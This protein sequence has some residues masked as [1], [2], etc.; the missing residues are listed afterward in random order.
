MIRVYLQYSYGGFKTFFIEGKEKNE[1]VSQEVSNG[2]AFDMPSDAHCYFQYGGAK[3]VYRY[4][5][6]GK[7]DLVVREIPSIHK[8]GDGRSIPCA[9]Q[10]V[11]DAADRNTLDYMVTDIVNDINGF[12]DFFA[13]LFRVRNGLRIDGEALRQWI[14]N[15]DT[16]FLCESKVEQILGITRPVTE[17][18]ILFVPMSS[19]FGI[20]QTVTNNVAKELKLPLKQVL[21]DKCFINIAELSKVQQ[22]ATITKGIPRPTPAMG[23]K[24]DS[25]GYKEELAAKEREIVALN[26]RVN[27]TLE[28]L[29]AEKQKAAALQKQVE[30]LQQELKQHKLF[31]YVLGGAAVLLAAYG[32]Y[33]LISK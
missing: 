26:A 30:K 12:H 24:V 7:L 29:K 25:K 31:I 33:S 13:N 14:E 3:I 32:L 27:G 16:P 1:S 9:V 21:N 10:F 15:H 11:G 5:G 23:E 20:D 19:N 2:E 4:L 28:D 18:I 6:N 17:G 22:K 8:D